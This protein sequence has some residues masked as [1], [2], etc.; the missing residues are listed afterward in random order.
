MQISQD[1]L[2][3]VVEG[4]DLDA[5]FYDQICA[6]SGKIEAAGYQIWLAEQLK[7]DDTGSSAGGKKAVLAHFDYFK[8]A[9]KLTVPTS[10]GKHS[11]AFMVDRDNEDVSGGRRRSPHVVYTDMFDVE[12]EIFVHG[13]DEEALAGML[14]LDSASATQLAS[15]LDGWIADLA[16][17]W[18]EWITLCTIAK[19]AGAGCDVGFGR[20]SWL[21][22]PKYGSVE[23]AKLAAAENKV[24]TSTRHSAQDF[25][26]ISSRIKTRINIYYAKGDGRRLIK[27]KWLPSYLMHRVKAHFGTAPV[28]YKGAADAVSRAYLATCNFTEKWANYYSDRLEPLV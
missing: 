3:V 8:A 7:D 24:S 19:A 17:S 26:V 4:K 5:R 18:R 14:S 23:T 1:S 9:G 27:G 21:N 11:I 20:E 16:N 25:N 13:S 2:F 28:S 6:S 15:D 22:K 12:A 10:S